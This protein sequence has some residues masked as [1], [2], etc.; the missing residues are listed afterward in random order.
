MDEKA[1]LE[2]SVHIEENRREG[3]WRGWRVD[4]TDIRNQLV[5]GRLAAWK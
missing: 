1:G 2:A 4:T 3:M 5:D